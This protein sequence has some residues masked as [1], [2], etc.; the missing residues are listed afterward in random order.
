MRAY[1]L[2]KVLMRGF[3]SNGCCPSPERLFRGT[4]L[5]E[6]P[7]TKSLTMKSLFEKSSNVKFGPFGKSPLDGLPAPLLAAIV[8]ADGKTSNPSAVRNPTAF[9]Y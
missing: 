2:S 7:S 3:G 9:R 4:A 8:L 5:S 1:Q 6:S